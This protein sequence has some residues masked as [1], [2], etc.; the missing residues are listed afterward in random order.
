MSGDLASSMKGLA[1]G[2]L[3]AAFSCQTA[4]EGPKSG[5]GATTPPA[6]ATPGITI[7]LHQHRP[8]AAPVAKY[9]ESG[10][11]QL[12]QSEQLV[13]SALQNSRFEHDPKL[14]RMIRGLAG[15]TPTRNDMPPELVDGLLAW[16]GIVD[17]PP[18]V[19]VVEVLPD[20]DE[21]WKRMSPACEEPLR[22]LTEVVR[23]VLDTPGNWK[24][25]VGVSP[26][27]GGGTRMMVGAL[28]R[29]FEMEPMQ[30]V[31]RMGKSVTLRGKVVSG[32]RSPE[33]HLVD[34]LGHWRKLPAAVGDDGTVSAQVGCKGTPGVYKVEVFANGQHGPEVVANFPLYCGVKRPAEIGYTLERLAPTL[35]TSTIEAAN[36]RELND[37]RIAAGLTPLNWDE[38]AAEVARA[39]SRDM[40][41]NAF[42]GHVSPTTG[43]ATRR[44]T[45]ARI[46]S[47][48]VRE[49]VAR[50]YG[51]R[52]IH[53][54]LMN[55]P[56]HRANL[57]AD[58]VTH[59][60]VGAVYGRREGDG[61]DAPRP[62]LLTQNFFARA[63]ADAP[64]NF[65]PELRRRVDEEARAR[66]WGKL[67]WDDRLSA[68]AQSE[69][70]ALAAGRAGRNDDE[71]RNAVFGLG[72][73]S[74]LQHSIESASF[75]SLSTLEVWSG[76]GKRHVG[77]GIARTRDGRGFVLLVYLTQ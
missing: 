18:Q 44:L 14:S 42:V 5:P 48:V 28:D 32:R 57:L 62:V 12:S 20:P 74:M 39:H 66:A 2:G 7:S 53:L 16:H 13:L 8:R 47:A 72:Y 55:S 26:G 37:A 33:V 64:T 65:V 45:K 60:G 50:G 52:S 24:I 40:M 46:D 76:A 15:A 51:P 1:L 75:R 43:D 21:C 49:N 23:S 73:Q 61:N 10:R 36:F 56:G 27:P 68:I 38:K 67:R 59:V 22:A 70:E 71:L 41:R 29:A 69:A 35:P 34:A 30:V 63:G 11:G 17:P 54:S 19:L 6:S 4:S 9:G 77:Y 31:L 3:L 25:G 58:D